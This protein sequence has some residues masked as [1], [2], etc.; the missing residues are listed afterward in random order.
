MKK[1]LVV[2]ASGATGK[3]LVEQLLSEN[4]E[5][6]AIVR[7]MNNFSSKIIKHPNLTFIIKNITDLSKEELRGYVK[8]CDAVC[9][10]LGHNLSFKGIF[11]EPRQ[12]VK[13]SIEKLCQSVLAQESKKRVKVILMNTS[14]NCNHDILEK[15][16]LS[17]RI[18]V[19]LLRWVLPPHVDNEN[20]ANYLR[21]NIGQDNESIQWVAVRP[22]SLTDEKDVTPYNIHKSP[23]SNVI[24]D[25]KKTSRINVANFMLHLCID[26]ALWEKY[27]GQMPVIYNDTQV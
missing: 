12:L 19:G 22:D 8:E 14:G 21:L 10:C 7:S 16:P 2:G 24:F 27:K 25:A 11:G 13:N 3:L 20:A 26:E 4:I 5:V 1:V 17:Q 6:M 9:S 23:V 15:P 18:I